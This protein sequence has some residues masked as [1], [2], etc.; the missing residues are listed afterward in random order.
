MYLVL[1]EIEEDV[2]TG[3][4]LGNYGHLQAEVLTNEAQNT[5]VCFAVCYEPFIPKRY[6]KCD[7]IH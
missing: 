4:D 3:F 7:S 1:V 6:V 2:D 5:E